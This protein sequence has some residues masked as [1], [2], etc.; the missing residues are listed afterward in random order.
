VVTGYF[1]E[2]EQTKYVDKISNCVVLQ[3]VRPTVS[4]SLPVTYT[5]LDRCDFEAAQLPAAPGYASSVRRLLYYKYPYQS[6]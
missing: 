5:F 2:K 3:Q 4:L 6:G 1:V